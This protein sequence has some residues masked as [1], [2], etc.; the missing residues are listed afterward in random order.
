MKHSM[1]LLNG[2]LGDIC[3]QGITAAA[4]FWF[5][6]YISYTGK[7]WTASH[8]RLIRSILLNVRGG[9]GDPPDFPC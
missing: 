2:Y 6:V 1:R 8:P 3:S 9:G 7:S 4:F 5:K